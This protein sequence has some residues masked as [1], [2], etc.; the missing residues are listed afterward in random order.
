[1]PNYSYECQK[2]KDR[3]DIN[4]RLADKPLKRCKKCRGKLVKLIGVPTVFMRGRT[5]GAIADM[6]D[7]KFSDEQKNSISPKKKGTTKEEPWY[8]K[9]LDKKTQK[10]LSK[11][12]PEQARKYV[13]TGKIT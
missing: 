7:A 3:F 11:L 8:N 1:M 10:K 4:Q 9:G 6:N 2:C 13:E 12:N 5:V